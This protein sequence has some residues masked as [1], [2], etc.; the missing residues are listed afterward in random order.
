MTPAIREGLESLLANIEERRAAVKRRKGELLR[1]EPTWSAAKELM[2]LNLE[3]DHLRLAQD[4]L[5]DAMTALRQQIKD[6][7]GDEAA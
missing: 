1:E 5:G 7:D 3:L 6:E 2:A 4:I